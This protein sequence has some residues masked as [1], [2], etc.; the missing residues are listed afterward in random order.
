MKILC[1]APS[2]WPAFQQG[3]PTSFI[4]GLNKALVEKGI[5]ITVY[6]TNINLEGK[7]FEN[8]EVDVDGV[9]VSYFSFQKRLE[10]LGAN[11]WQS[12]PIC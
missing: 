12:P 6:T 4:H 10:F 5:D 9:K 3:G 1:I 7:V 11:G 8:C 2:Y